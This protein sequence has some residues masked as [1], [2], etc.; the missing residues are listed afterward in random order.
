MQV[1]SKVFGD[2][3]TI[4]NAVATTH[5]RYLSVAYSHSTYHLFPNLGGNATHQILVLSCVATIK[6]I[7]AKQMP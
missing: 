5:H 2:Y 3:S 6:T 7:I 1:A 4:K